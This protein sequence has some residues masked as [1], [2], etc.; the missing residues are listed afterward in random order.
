MQLLPYKISVAPLAK[1]LGII[2][3]VSFICNL[4]VGVG[5]VADETL[6]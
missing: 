5:G 3:G 2:I 1:V 6:T 4:N